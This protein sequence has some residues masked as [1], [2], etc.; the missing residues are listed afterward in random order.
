MN[1]LIFGFVE[2]LQIKRNTIRLTKKGILYR[3]FFSFLVLNIIIINS[4]KG[5]HNKASSL[6]DERTVFLT[7]RLDLSLVYKEK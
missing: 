1:R 3:P 6:A 7:N 2:F 5:N 4:E